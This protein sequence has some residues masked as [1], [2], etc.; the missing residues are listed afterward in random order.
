[1]VLV[2]YATDSPVQLL[3]SPTDCVSVLF[4]PIFGSGV[5]GSRVGGPLQYS[6]SPGF[7]FTRAYSFAINNVYKLI[8]DILLPP[9]PLAFAYYPFYN[10]YIHLILFSFIE[11]MPY[12]RR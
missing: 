11:I 12:F 7:G 6:V 1:M 3:G 4:M 8:Q 9:Q 5:V 10:L 2:R